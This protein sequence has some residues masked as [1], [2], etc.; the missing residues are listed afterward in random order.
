[1]KRTPVRSSN[2]ASIGYDPETSTLEVE[3]HGG[4]LYEYYR[5]PEEHYLNLTSG[6]RSVG[7]YL[8]MQIKGRYRYRQ[9]R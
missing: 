3:F 2:V 6:T 7:N 4:G 9:L 5:V 8:N 1:M